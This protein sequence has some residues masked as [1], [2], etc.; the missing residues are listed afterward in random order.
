MKDIEGW[1]YNFYEKK[2]V[3]KYT[4]YAVK[5]FLNAININSKKEFWS[6]IDDLNFWRVYLANEKIF[7]VVIRYNCP[8]RVYMT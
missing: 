1:Y 2:D 4:Y 3:E 6:N 8:I 5:N 7:W